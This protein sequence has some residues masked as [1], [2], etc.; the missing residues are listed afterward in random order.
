MV[1]LKLFP[2]IGTEKLT[3]LVSLQLNINNMRDD[4]QINLWY[5]SGNTKQ[6]GDSW[7]GKWKMNLPKNIKIRTS[8]MKQPIC[9]T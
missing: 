1:S 8:F 9:I 2:G 5:G 4:E 6:S 7:Q 3:K